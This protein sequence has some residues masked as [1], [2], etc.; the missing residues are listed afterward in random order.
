MLSR[1]EILKHCQFYKGE[2][3]DARPPKD[4]DRKNEGKLWAAERIICENMPELVDPSNPRQSLC[5]Y[6][7]YYVGKWDPYDFRE[8]METYFEKCPNLRGK[9]IL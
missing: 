5:Q 9:I 8:V 1:E 2:G 6:V 7:S 3:R 4:F